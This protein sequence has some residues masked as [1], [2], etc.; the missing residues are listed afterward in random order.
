HV[1]GVRPE[2]GSHHALAPA[3]GQ[4]QP[5]GLLDVLVAV[6]VAQIPAGAGQDRESPAAPEEVAHPIV[7]VI[8]PAVIALVSASAGSLQVLTRSPTRAAASPPI[9]TVAEPWS[10]VPLLEGCFWNDVP[11][12]VGTCLGLL[13]ASEPT[14]AAS[15]PPILTEEIVLPVIVPENG[16]G[17]G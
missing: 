12:G 4:Q 2:A 10:T 7:T 6:D 17:S 9:V 5:Q 15:S 1:A 8:S 11:G 13:V 3:R 16:C 14:T